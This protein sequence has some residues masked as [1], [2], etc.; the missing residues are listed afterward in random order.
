MAWQ[1]IRTCRTRRVANPWPATPRTSA[2]CATCWCCAR[3]LSMF[4]P[5]ICVA[6]WLNRARAVVCKRETSGL[7]RS[8]F[9][10]IVRDVVSEL[11]LADSKSKLNCVQ[12]HAPRHIRQCRSSH[13]HLLRTVSIRPPQLW[14]VDSDVSYRVDGAPRLA[15]GARLRCDNNRNGWWRGRVVRLPRTTPSLYNA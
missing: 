6:V 2:V 13:I 10:R 15:R 7:H 11:E 9:S 3:W 5:A 14:L 1:M 12:W 4:T 8:D